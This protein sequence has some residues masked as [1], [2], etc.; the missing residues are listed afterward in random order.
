[1]TQKY[2]GRKVE[3]TKSVKHSTK[4][5]DIKPKSKGIIR[6][7][8]NIIKPNKRFDNIENKPK[9]NSIVEVTTL[10]QEPINVKVVKNLKRYFIGQHTTLGVNAYFDYQ[11]I[12]E[13][14]ING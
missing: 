9:L 1:M 10:D 5:T 7:L 14:D 2:Q 13:Y 8:L 3:R 6:G 4:K 11:D 12:T